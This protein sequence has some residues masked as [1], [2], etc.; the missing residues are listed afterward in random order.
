ML[1][2]LS[3]LQSYSITISISIITTDRITYNSYLLFKL[4]VLPTKTIRFLV[5]NNY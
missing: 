3:A 4:L 2:V 5:S 1:A